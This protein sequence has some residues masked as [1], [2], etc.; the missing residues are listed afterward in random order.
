MEL[1]ELPT[2]PEPHHLLELS[3][4]HINKLFLQD[5]D[6]FGNSVYKKVAIL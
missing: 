4:E 6:G 2:A 5:G 3:S 1:L